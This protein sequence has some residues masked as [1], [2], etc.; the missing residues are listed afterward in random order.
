MKNTHLLQ[1]FIYIIYNISTK[2]FLLHS[3]YKNCITFWDLRF[4]KKSHFELKTILNKLYR[5]FFE[6]GIHSCIV[7]KKWDICVL[8]P[9]ADIKKSKLTQQLILVQNCID[10]IWTIRAP[11]IEPRE[12]LQIFFSCIF[13][14]IFK[15][16]SVWILKI[17]IFPRDKNILF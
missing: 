1:I 4:F 7:D 17:K 5:L 9:V 13:Y 10:L 11:K 12:I 3:F 16:N 2:L 8:W 14:V 15:W 6:L